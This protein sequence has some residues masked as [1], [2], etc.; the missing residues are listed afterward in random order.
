MTLGKALPTEEQAEDQR[1]ERFRAARELIRK[2]WRKAITLAIEGG[3]VV[4]IGAIGP[5]DQ[6]R[7]DEYREEIAE[8]LAE[9]DGES[10]AAGGGERKPINGSLLT[11]DRIEIR[12]IDFTRAGMRFDWNIYASVRQAVLNRGDGTQYRINRPA[13]N[14]PYEYSGMENWNSVFEGETATYEE[15][16]AIIER[17]IAKLELQKQHVFNNPNAPWRLKPASEKQRDMLRKFKVPFGDD[18]TAGEASD[19]IDRLL[20]RKRA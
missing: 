8:I 7:L 6:A 15:A 18:L 19:T 5:R 14:G 16:R 11:S 20:K 1:K 12:D 9:R 3:R 2:L 4:V 17:H 13:E 10:I